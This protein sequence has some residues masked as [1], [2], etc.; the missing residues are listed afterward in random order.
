MYISNP[1]HEGVET[2][3]A[4]LYDWSNICVKDEVIFD[5]KYEQCTDTDTVRLASVRSKERNDR[6]CI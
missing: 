1:F 4:F 6:R 5:A 2:P 3:A